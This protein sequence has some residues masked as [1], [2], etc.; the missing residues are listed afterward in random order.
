[1]PL[2]IEE[3][4]DLTPLNTLAIAAKAD[5][6][7]RI[8]DPDQIPEAVAFA[9]SKNLSTLP[10]GSGS[11]V[12][13]GEAELHA[14][15][16]KIEMRGRAVD[17]HDAYANIRIGAGENWDDFVWA[18]ENKFTGIESLSLVPGTVGAAPVQNVGAYGQEVSETITAVEAYD[19]ETEDFVTLGNT[20]CEFRYRNS[21]FKHSRRYVITAV[22]FQLDH[23]VATVAP[24]VYASLKG[25]LDRRGISK[26]SGAD[27]R[28][29]VVHIRRSK[30][31][32][33]AVTPTAGSFFHNPAIATERFQRL[34]KLFAN[35]PHWPTLDGKIKLS[36]AWVIEQCGLK[37]YQKNGVGTYEK[38]ALCL[39]NPGHK[40]AADILKFR[41]QVVR[42]V[43]NKFD[44]SL[45]ME[46]ELIT[47]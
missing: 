18:V 43:E 39:I 32:D 19:T 15:L 11:N 17:R 28:K 9:R 27:I 30:L 1:M 24:P 4:V 13:I 8:T 23:G 26:P 36:A 3:Q 37:G 40:P 6:L 2:Q 20:D 21:I 44:I 5:F 34:Q 16:L 25:E 35:V 41:D 45:Q 12:V 22:T 10:W 33:P 29:A 38:Q 47:A 14:V 31:P 7:I 46:P 42:E